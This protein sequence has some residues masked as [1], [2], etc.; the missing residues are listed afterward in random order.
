MELNFEENQQLLISVCGQ[1][2]NFSIKISALTLKRNS[3]KTANIL[4]SFVRSLQMSFRIFICALNRVIQPNPKGVGASCHL[5]MSQN[6]MSS[7]FC[8]NENQGEI[9]GDFKQ[10]ISVS[11]LGAYEIAGAFRGR[12]GGGASWAPDSRGLQNEN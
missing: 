2:V 8:L 4:A 7:K 10:G 3:N 12:G 1:P 5:V 9:L 6:N 11:R